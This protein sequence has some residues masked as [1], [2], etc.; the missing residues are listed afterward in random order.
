LLK[1]VSD[2][3]KQDNLLRAIF[4]MAPEVGAYLESVAPSQPARCVPA[5]TKVRDL[6]RNHGIESRPLQGEIASG[7]KSWTEH[8]VNVVESEARIVTVDFAAWQFAWFSDSDLVVLIA[9]SWAEL[10]QALAEEY[11]WWLPP[12][13]P[14]VVL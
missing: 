3:A 13:K 10:S 7:P 11:R 1:Y 2:Q 8:F 5:V 14:S 6:L 9:P 4:E 12:V